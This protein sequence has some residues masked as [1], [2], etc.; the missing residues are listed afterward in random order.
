[1]MLHSL[2]SSAISSSPRSSLPSADTNAVGTPSFV[3][4]VATLAGA[5]PGYGVH[6]L[7]SSLFKPFSLARKSAVQQREKKTAVHCDIID[8][9]VCVPQARGSAHV[10]QQ[11]SSTAAGAAAGGD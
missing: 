8:T 2:F 5:P 6:D 9:Q 10:Q 1:M 7:T 11:Y 3:S 4:A